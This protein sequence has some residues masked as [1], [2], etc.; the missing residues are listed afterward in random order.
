[1]GI[2]F[3]KN[4]LTDSTLMPTWWISNLDWIFDDK[5]FEKSCGWTK[6]PRRILTNYI[7]K[8]ISSVFIIKKG[9]KIVSPKGCM[10]AIFTSDECACVSFMRHIRNSI[11]HNNATIIT[12]KKQKFIRFTDYSNNSRDVQTADIM[13]SMD[14]LIKLQQKYSSTKIAPVESMSNTDLAA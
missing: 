14:F 3:F 2:N 4:I 10:Y 9:N 5:K 12:S 8:S 1:M 6:G 7:N 11:A 13:I